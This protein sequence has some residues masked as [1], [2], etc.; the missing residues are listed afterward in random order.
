MSNDP[1]PE[2]PVTPPPEERIDPNVVVG[3][4][5]ALGILAG[6]TGQL[7]TGISDIKG[8]AQAPPPP[9]PSEPP[10]EG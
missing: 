7:L 6:G 10:A 3:G 1:R 4:V 9:P 8:S 5:A 2:P